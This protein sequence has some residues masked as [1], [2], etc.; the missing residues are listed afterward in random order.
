MAHVEEDGELVRRVAEGDAEALRALYGLYG[1]LV[2]GVAHRVLGDRQL[3]ED[4]TQ[5]VF[6][7]LWRGA[8][9]YDELPVEARN[10]VARLEEV[11]GVPAAIVSTGSD[12][13][14]TIVRD[15]K[16]VGAKN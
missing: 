4:C 12:R 13:D 9:S 3:A 15:A 8:R 14:E 10:Y 2:F 5:D 1:K 6:V 16:W 7:A 11:S